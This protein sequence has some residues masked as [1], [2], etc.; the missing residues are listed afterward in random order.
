MNSEEDYLH[1]IKNPSIELK[2]L[3]EKNI[4]EHQ[5]FRKKVINDIS[6]IK[7]LEDKITELRN[8]SFNWFNQHILRTDKSICS[9]MKDFDIYPNK[10]IMKNDLQEVFL[11]SIIKYEKEYLN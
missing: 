6:K 1:S 11:K 4:I 2:E 5:F 3:I 8:F 7:N 9:L 10:N